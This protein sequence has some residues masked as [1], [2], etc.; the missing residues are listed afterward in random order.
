[1][2]AEKIWQLYKEREAE[3]K[4]QRDEWKSL[5]PDGQ[6]YA[7]L[8][9]R[10]DMCRRAYEGGVRYCRELGLTPAM[11]EEKACVE[12]LKAQ[13]DQLR[14]RVAWAYRWW[15]TPKMKRYQEMARRLDQE[16]I[17][18][19]VG[20]FTSIQSTRGFLQF[21]MYG[22]RE[23]DAFQRAGYPIIRRIPEGAKQLDIGLRFE[24]GCWSLKAR[25]YVRES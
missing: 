7:M 4:R 6:R 18:E 3:E 8:L 20:I 22:Y 17:Y 2:N 9:Y 10:Y 19:A 15:K 14:P 23:L 25:S 24:R 5:H 1:M 13:L 12:R 21:G 16:G 11:D